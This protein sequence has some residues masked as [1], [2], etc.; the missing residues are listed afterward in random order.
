MVTVIVKYDLAPSFTYER[1]QNAF[2]QAVPSYTNLPGLI[3]KYFLIAGDAQSAGSV[4]L[5]ETIE[6]AEAFHDEDWREFM[7]Q[8]YGHR[9]SVEILACPIV[10]DN[11]SRT[12][13]KS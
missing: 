9:P 2:E 5:W 13:L 10:V 7:R 4:Y 12:V 11:A 8:K 1:V 3:R 6:Q